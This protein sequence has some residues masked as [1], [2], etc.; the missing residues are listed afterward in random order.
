MLLLKTQTAWFIHLIFGFKK[1]THITS[2]NLTWFKMTCKVSIFH[3]FSPVT[4][5]F[6]LEDLPSTWQFSPLPNYLTIYTYLIKVPPKKKEQSSFSR[7][8]PTESRYFYIFFAKRACSCPTPIP[9]T[10]VPRHLAKPKSIIFRC[11]EAFKSWW[12]VRLTT[13]FTLTVDGR[14]LAKWLTSWGW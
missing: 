13:R 3:G 11:S 2:T 10:A 1:N 8:L 12:K 14:H 4:W 6:W 9:Q 5:L 7:F